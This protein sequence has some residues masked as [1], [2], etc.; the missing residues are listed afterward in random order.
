MEIFL[1]SVKQLHL[2]VQRKPRNY[3]NIPILNEFREKNKINLISVKIMKLP[4][5]LYSFTTIS[6]STTFPREI[7]FPK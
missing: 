5:R 3:L 4:V 6:R 1:I 2:Y 7:N